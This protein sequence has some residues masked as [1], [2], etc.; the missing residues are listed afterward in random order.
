MGS[1]TH[2]LPNRED[3]RVWGPVNAPGETVLMP[4]RNAWLWRTLVALL[5]L[6]TASIVA[7][8][9]ASAERAH[10]SDPAGDAWNIGDRDSDFENPDPVGS[11]NGDI[12]SVSVR[13]RRYALVIRTTFHRLEQPTD[14]TDEGHVGFER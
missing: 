12:A 1:P 7:V 14:P 10:W 3:R 5:T 4:V 9:P 13:H 11:I 6:A 2:L 8:P